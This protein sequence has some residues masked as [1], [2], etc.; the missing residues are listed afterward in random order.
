MKNFSGEK[1]FSLEY[2]KETLRDMVIAKQEEIEK[3]KLE[4]SGYR[5]AILQD[6]EMLGLKQEIERLNNI[7]NELEKW[8]EKN[9]QF[10][11][12]SER[13]IVWE[14]K[15]IDKLQELKGVDKK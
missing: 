11:L 7:I 4:L 3:L 15:L 13:C 1:I 10:Q 14:D 9:K 5:Q 12:I 2:D 6:K 8:I